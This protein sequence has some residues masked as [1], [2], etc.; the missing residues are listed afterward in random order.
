MLVPM[1]HEDSIRLKSEI[2]FSPFGVESPKHK[3]LNGHI[4]QFIQVL[5]S[6]FVPP[7]HLLRDFN[8]TCVLNSVPPHSLVASV[9]MYRISTTEANPRAAWEAMGGPSA[10]TSKQR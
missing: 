1:L 4:Q 7:L 2:L 5:L 8:M 3:Q 6:N 9:T 10:L